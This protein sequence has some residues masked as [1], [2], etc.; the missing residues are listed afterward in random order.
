M[1]IVPQ[2]EGER[3]QLLIDRIE[4]LEEEK[5]SLSEDIKDVFAEAKAV[6]YDVKVIRRIIAL[7]KLDESERDEL[8]SLIDMYKTALGM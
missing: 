8:E 4:T 6:G 2:V 5:K 1:A 3:L 7:R